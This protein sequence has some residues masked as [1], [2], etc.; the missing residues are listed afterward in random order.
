M[1]LSDYLQMSVTPLADYVPERKVRKT[2][3]K[4]ISPNT[5]DSRRDQAIARYRSVM[6][7]EWMKAGEVD[8]R[9]G[10]V[11]GSDRI[12]RKWIHLGIVEKRNFGGAETYNNQQ[13]FEW[14]M[15]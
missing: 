12:M 9:L 2:K 7:S 13:G 4:R 15:K 10:R 1:N 11:N 5:L 3:P 8:K 14:R 6:G